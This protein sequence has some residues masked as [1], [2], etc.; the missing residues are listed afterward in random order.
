MLMKEEVQEA[1]VLIIDDLRT[2]I[3]IIE[4]MLKSGGYK[5]IHAITDPREAVSAYLRVKPDIVLLDLMMPYMDGFEI[6]EA[7]KKLDPKGFLSVII[8]TANDDMINRNRALS[9]GARDFLGKP[10]DQVEALNRI[11]NILETRILYNKLHNEKMTLEQKVDERTQELYESQVE[12]ATRLAKAGEFRDN[13]TGYHDL[14]VG[15][16]AEVMAKAYGINQKQADNLRYTVPLH[17][18]GKIGIPDHILLK[19]GKLNE[20][21]WEYMKSHTVIGA[22]ILEG[23]KSEFVNQAEIIARTHHEKWNG[24]GYPQG[25]SGDSIPIEGRIS[26][27]CDVFDALV[28]NRPYKNAWSIEKAVEHIEKQK[29]EHFDPDLVDVFL[30]KIDEIIRIFK[31]Y[32]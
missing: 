15:K 12:T 20:E 32:T 14:R 19:P 29:G 18:I 25:L 5:N 6:L 10:F 23:G 7:F 13:E 31:E 24:T 1:Q 2:N 30:E 16:Y 21:E 3:F 17:D 26:A 9:L 11:H 22:Q 27:I 4:K 8:L 28:S